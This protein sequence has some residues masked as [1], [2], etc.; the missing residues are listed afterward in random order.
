MFFCIIIASPVLVTIMPVRQAATLEE[1]RRLAPRPGV[2][3]DVRQFLEFPARFESYFNDHFSLRSLLIRGY[4]LIRLHLQD[5]SASRF[6]ISGS[7]G[8]LFFTGDQVLKDYCGAVLFSEK[9]LEFRRIL[10][11]QKRNWLEEQGIAYLFV[12]PPNK[13]SIYPEYM[14]DEYNRLKGR[15]RLD[16]F[17]D[18]LRKHSDIAVLDL[19]EAL[20][21]VKD[22]FRLYHKT[23]THW[24]DAGAFYAYRKIIQ[25]IDG[26]LADWHSEPWELSEFD[27]VSENGKG[28]D[29]ALLMGLQDTLTED[30]I[31]FRPR[32][33]R[34][35]EK[36]VLPSYLGRVWVLSNRTLD[37]FAEV[38]PDGRGTMVV[39]HDSFAGSLIPFLSE[40]FRRSVYFW[41]NHPDYFLLRDVVEKERPDIVVEELLERF[42]G[43]M[44]TEQ[45]FPSP[46]LETE[47][48][49][50]A[51]TVL[52]IA[53]SSASTGMFSRVREMTISGAPD[54][55]AMHVTENDPRFEL[56]E[57]RVPDTVRSIVRIVISSPADTYIQLFYQTKDERDFGSWLS[58][59]APLKKGRNIVFIAIPNL[60][61]IGRLRL[62]PG[63]V[64]GDY[65]LHELEI[66]GSGKAIESLH[67]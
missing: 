41:R 19:R 51:D 58:R 33:P 2:P 6:V 44:R 65:I 35:A 5:R 45:Q 39:F 67:P 54:G 61:R 7:D 31:S 46:E 11:E 40:H 22:K 30:R 37:P 66:R 56:P 62:D 20:T 52:H 60:N 3:R 32:I 63:A 16:Q 34:R 29:L 9:E 49:R 1:K 48:S 13:H 38:T 53:P 47:F 55:F 36:V 28:G 50:S 18:Y 17:A 15:T 59:K 25:A 10:L 4:S 26:R 12:I 27:V 14:P 42:I 8:W 21:S 57:S 43:Y 24:N 23:D 64:Q